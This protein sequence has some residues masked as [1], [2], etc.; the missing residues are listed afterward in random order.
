MIR[1]VE[2]PKRKRRAPAPVEPTLPAPKKRAA[3]PSADPGHRVVKVT[4]TPPAVKV[5]ALRQAMRAP[6][7]Q[8]VDKTEWVR[9]TRVNKAAKT[10]PVAAYLVE[11]SVPYDLVTSGLRGL[12]AEGVRFTEE[13]ED[14]RF[15]E[16][17]G[18]LY[19]MPGDTRTRAEVTATGI[20]LYRLAGGGAWKRFPSAPRLWRYPQGL[21][22]HIAKVSD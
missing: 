2:P 16:V 22:R 8:R 17:D 15:G 18:T 21:I 11:G 7:G 4:V 19:A 12:Q 20:A 6:L 3:K 13:V 1:V 5:K 9:W 14:G 10:G